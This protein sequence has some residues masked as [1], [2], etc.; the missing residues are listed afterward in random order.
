MMMLLCPACAVRRLA[1]SFSGKCYKSA[2]IVN[3][4]ELCVV[5]ASSPD[6]DFFVSDDFGGAISLEAMRAARQPFVRVG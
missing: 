2:K 1:Q 4:Q 3:R 6:F 5:P